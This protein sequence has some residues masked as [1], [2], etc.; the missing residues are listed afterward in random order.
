MAGTRE[1]KKE[2]CRR[3]N[4]RTAFVQMQGPLMQPTAILIL[5]LLLQADA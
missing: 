5:T 1:S 2:K 3:A 4:S